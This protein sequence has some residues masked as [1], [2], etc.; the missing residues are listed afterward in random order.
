MSTTV[1]LFESTDV[2]KQELRSSSVLSEI[3]ESILIVQ[4]GVSNLFYKKGTLKFLS[5]FIQT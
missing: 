3:F 5:K 4:S 2:L 1:A